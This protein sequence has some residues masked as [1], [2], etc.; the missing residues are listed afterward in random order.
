MLIL[1]N[2]SNH[3]GYNMRKLSVFILAIFISLPV[4]NGCGGSDVEVEE[5]IPPSLSERMIYMLTTL[6]KSAVSYNELEKSEVKPYLEKAIVDMDEA[7]GLIRNYQA[8]ED[9][10]DEFLT[11]VSDVV[12]RAASSVNA[13]AIRSDVTDN[14]YILLE[15]ALI[16]VAGELVIT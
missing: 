9:L 1:K 7:L 8:D 15:D 13:A 2:Q 12:K 4:L 3:T 14:R 11:A 5:G 16:Y 10:P 6:K